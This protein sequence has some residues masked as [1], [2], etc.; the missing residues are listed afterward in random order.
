MVLISH[1]LEELKKKMTAYK[2]VTKIL[3]P[4]EESTKNIANKN[5][6]LENSEK[7]LH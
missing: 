3:I 2:H 4:N 1:R 5:V 7:R 6:F